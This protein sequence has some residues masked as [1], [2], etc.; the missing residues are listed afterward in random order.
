MDHIELGRK[1]EEIAS[2]YLRTKGWEILSSN[3]KWNRGEVDLV[4]KV[5]SCLKIIEVKTRN[6]S[7]FGEPHNAVNRKKQKQIIQVANH[8]I[9]ENS[10]DLEVEF[11]VISIVLNQTKMEL[12]HIENAFYPML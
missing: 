11:D 4:C 2:N 3:Y 12:E 9:Q 1:G 5:D 7:Y 10:I 6:S 8:Y